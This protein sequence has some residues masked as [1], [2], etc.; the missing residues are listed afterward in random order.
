MST[1]SLRMIEFQIGAPCLAFNKKLLSPAAVTDILDFSKVK[2]KFENSR[3]KVVKY[4]T[5]QPIREDLGKEGI[6]MAKATVSE[7]NSK[8]SSL[9][10]SAVIGSLASSAEQLGA[11]KTPSPSRSKPVT[12]VDVSAA[13]PAAPSGALVVVGERCDTKEGDKRYYAQVVEVQSDCKVRLEFGTVVT[14]QIITLDKTVNDPLPT[15]LRQFIDSQASTVAKS[16]DKPDKPPKPEHPDKPE[17]KPIKLDKLDP[18]QVTALLKQWRLY[19]F[20]G[21]RF[22]SCVDVYLYDYALPELSD[23]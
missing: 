14:S 7:L 2:V 16:L 4:E 15:A 13:S 12:P 22:V 10:A 11:V 9:R 18:G 8:L 1:D 23:G 5:L 21:D 6:E 20:F 17:K 3:V 19:K